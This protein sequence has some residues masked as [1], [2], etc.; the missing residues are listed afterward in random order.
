MVIQ[1]NMSPKAI[2]EV[3][4]GAATILKQYHVPI[5]ETPLEAVVKPNALPA[6]LKELNDFVGSSMT[7]CVKGG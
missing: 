4:E 1:S 2:V 7:T 6:L 5:M 3:W